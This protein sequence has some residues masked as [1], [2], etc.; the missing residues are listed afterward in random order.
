VAVRVGGVEVDEDAGG[1]AVVVPVVVVP[2]VVMRGAAVAG[3]L[4][5]DPPADVQPVTA[6]RPAASS[7]TVRTAMPPAAMV[8]DP[9]P[10]R[11]ESAP[12]TVDRGVA[13]SALDLARSVVLRADRYPHIPMSA[14]CTRPCR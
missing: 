4:L 14:H 5:R 1:V 10:R 6:S 12:R 8:A 7:V 3:V 13:A 9:T 11:A 2:G